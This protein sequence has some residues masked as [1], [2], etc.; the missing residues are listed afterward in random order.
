MR[1]HSV[2]Q[3][4]YLKGPRSAFW[5]N[6]QSR[7]VGASLLTLRPKER[8]DIKEQPRASAAITVPL[9]AVVAGVLRGMKIR[10]DD[11]AIR[12]FIS[13]AQPRIPVMRLDKG[14][15]ECLALTALFVPV[16]IYLFVIS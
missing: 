8:F 6:S 11:T 13:H 16:A 10:P 12:L 1:T 4:K 2:V 7:I 5:H 14:V 15:R 9:L 3:R